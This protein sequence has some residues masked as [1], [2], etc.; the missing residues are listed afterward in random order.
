MTVRAV[1]GAGLGVFATSAIPAGTRLISETAVLTLPETADLPDLYTLLMSLPAHRQAAY[2]SLSAYKRRHDETDWIPAA[3]AL[4]GDGP[5]AGFEAYCDAILR[6]WLIYETNRFTVR[7]KSGA[8]DRMGVFALAARLNH[9]C[10]P[11]VFHRHSHVIGRLTIHALRDIAPGEQVCT[12]YIDV[13]RPTAARRKLLR[14]WGFRCGCALCGGQG[15]GGKGGKEEE[16]ESRRKKLE[17]MTARMKRVE[18]KR[19]E[20]TRDWSQWDYA[21]A[22]GPLEELVGLMEREGLD[23]SDTLGE[24]LGVGAEY[25]MGVGWWEM[26]VKWAERAREIEERC[27]GTDSSEWAEANLR[28]EEARKGDPAAPVAPAQGG[29]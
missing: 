24:V 15:K 13:A 1:P 17:E 12:S 6:A 26:A 28:V 23:E 29:K 18:T 16:V 11:N 14:H 3:R 2:W 8:R 7:S 21:K 10:A 25:A 9:D 4:Y 27:L 20:G 22:L 19:V 5:S